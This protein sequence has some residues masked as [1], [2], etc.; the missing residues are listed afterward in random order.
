MLRVVVLRRPV[1]S[2]RL[3]LARCFSGKSKGPA[4]ADSPKFGNTHAKDDVRKTR[5][6]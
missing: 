4:E 3:P 6:Q 1:V 5:T 2:S